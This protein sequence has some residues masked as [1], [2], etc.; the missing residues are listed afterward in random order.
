MFHCEGN[1]E[2][3]FKRGEEGYSSR[4]RLLNGEYK[5]KVDPT[6]VNAETILEKNAWKLIQE[7][8]KQMLLKID[9]EDIDSVWL[10]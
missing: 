7:S 10:V 3:N 2:K 1:V 4:S 8:E 5:M 9:L 6:M